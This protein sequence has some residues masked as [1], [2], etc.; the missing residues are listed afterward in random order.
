MP[1]EGR[2]LFRICQFEKI[3][4]DVLVLAFGQAGDYSALVNLPGIMIQDGAV[5]VGADMMTGAA[6]VFAGGD[7]VPSARNATAAVGLGKIAARSID[8][9]LRGDKFVPQPNAEIADLKN[10]NTWYYSDAPRTVRPMI[11]IVRRTSGFAEVVGNLSEDNALF[12]ARRCTSCVNCFDCD[13]CYGVCPY[14]AVVK[15]GPGNRFKFNY[16]Y[17]KGCGICVSEC[18]CGPIKMI[19]EAI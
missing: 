10:M 3:D 14:N 16:D 15:L 1:G 13:N 18:P 9:F 17:C 12:E 11:D 8:A 6:G 4:A 5:Q 19:P 2:E 7:M